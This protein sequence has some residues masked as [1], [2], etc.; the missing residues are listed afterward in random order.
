MDTRLAD[1]IRHSRAGQ[2][3][4]AILRT[5]VHCG[6]C[7][8]TCPT[9]QLLGDEL[10]GPRGRIYLIKALL[11]GREVTEKTRQHLD[12]CLTCRSCETT[13][14]SGVQYVHLL[15]IGRQVLE[16]K[17]PRRRQDALRRRLLREALSRPAIF[18]P[19]IRLG[20]MLRPLLPSA[21][22]DKLPRP[23]PGEHREG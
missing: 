8:A 17:L 11:E 5:C 23:A 14:P 19:A 2:Q 16:E 6:F 12:R 10:D 13:C 9:Y 15:D 20:R 4:E 7:T 22:A 18:G 1:F 21:L 3:A